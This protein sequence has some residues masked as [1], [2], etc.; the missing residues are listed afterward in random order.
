[1]STTDELRRLCAE[2]GSHARIEY[3]RSKIKR[4]TIAELRKLLRERGVRFNEFKFMTQW[5]GALGES[6]EAY[7]T[8]TFPDALL[9]KHICLTPAQAIAA[10][11]GSVSE[12]VSEKVSERTCR[13]EET[14]RID[15]RCYGDPHGGEVYHIHV[16][17]CS[18]CGRTFE[19]VN[20]GYEFCPRCGARVVDE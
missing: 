11:L 12:K 1:M 17:E 13:A 20:G 2:G 9:V 19:H 5:T 16:M 10:T 4:A 8:D 14:E 7:P 15:T 3:L 18:A 6:V